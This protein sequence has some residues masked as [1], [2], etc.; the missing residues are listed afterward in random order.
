MRSII[1]KQE[2]HPAAIQQS[3]VQVT[4]AVVVPENSK[5]HKT[6][7][8]SS[9]LLPNVDMPISDMGR[10]SSNDDDALCGSLGDI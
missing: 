10:I 1:L 7:A 4:E 3:W 9:H 5:D 8:A 2:V 6:G